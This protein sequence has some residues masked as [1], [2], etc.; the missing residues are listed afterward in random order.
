[1]SL[2][3]ELDALRAEF[4]LL[5]AAG[6]RRAVRRQGRRIAA[7]GSIGLISDDA[8]RCYSVW[9]WKFESSSLQQ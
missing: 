9:N 6:P 4:V 8:G 3:D 5:G 2:Q 1:M 7:E